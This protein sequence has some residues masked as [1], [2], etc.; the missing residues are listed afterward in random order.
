M[1]DLPMDLRDAAQSL[2]FKVAE[3]DERKVKPLVTV[4]KT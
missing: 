3:C 2:L 4:A 1:Y